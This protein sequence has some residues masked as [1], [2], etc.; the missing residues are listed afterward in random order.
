MSNPPPTPLIALRS[1]LYLAGL[2]VTVIPYAFLVLAWGWLPM[3]R[4]YW[5]ILGW[6][7]YAVWSARVI[8]GIRWEVRGR[9]NLPDGPAIVLPK[10]QS[11][12]ETLFLTTLM[13]RPLCF[14]YK[15]ELHWLPF[16]GWGLWTLNMIHIDRAK[17]HDAFE[18]VVEQG[19]EK[20]AQGS[21]IIIF[22]EGTR[23]APGAAPRYKTG[24]PRLAVRTGAPVIPI[25]LNSGEVWPRKAFLKM[26]GTITVSIGPLIRTEG[27]SADDVAQRVETWIEDEMHRIA[28][29]R[30]TQTQPATAPGLEG[31]RA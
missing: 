7:R 9:E 27:L 29:H 17:G 18:Q 30:Y 2:V 23:R 22:P 15:R 12:W 1:A 5:M 11:A 6:T 4:R 14:V 21:W 25:A 10:H 19:T 31:S 24:G 8:C 20:L 26:P 28:P 3:P 13:P 16:F